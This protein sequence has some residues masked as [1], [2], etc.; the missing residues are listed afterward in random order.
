MLCAVN[1]AEYRG[2]YVEIHARFAAR[3]GASPAQLVEAVVCSIPF[4]GVAA[5]VAGANGVSAALAS[6]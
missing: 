5:W 6:P 2:D 3:G 4:A 1:A